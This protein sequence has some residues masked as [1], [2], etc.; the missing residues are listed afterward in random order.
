EIVSRVVRQLRALAAVRVNGVDLRWY[1]VTEHDLGTIRRPLGCSVRRIDSDGGPAT[2]VPVRRA[3]SRLGAVEYDLRA[4]RGPIWRTLALRWGIG[5]VRVACT[6]SIHDVNLLWLAEAVL[7]VN[8]PCAVV[9][10]RLH[11][12]DP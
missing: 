4:V 10:E 6:V 7:F 3:D 9:Q 12:G 2:P 8:G 1:V 11:K 5:D